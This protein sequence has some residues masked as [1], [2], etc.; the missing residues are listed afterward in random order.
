M[1]RMQ[2][3]TRIPSPWDERIR[4]T[5]QIAYTVVYTTLL[6]VTRSDAA[7]FADAPSQPKQSIS[8][9]Y[10]TAAPLSLVPILL[11]FSS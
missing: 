4:V 2:Q 6:T 3:K 7:F 10:H 11:F 5:T 9:G 1:V 8:Q